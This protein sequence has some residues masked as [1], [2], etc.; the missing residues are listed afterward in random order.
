VDTRLGRLEG[1]E[2]DAI[3]LACAGLE[4][5]GRAEEGTPVAPEALLPAAGQGCLALEARADDSAAVE[6]A[7]AL[8]DQDALVALLAERALVRALDASC[9]TPVGALASPSGEELRLSAY[10]GLPDGSHWIRDALE[11]D[12]TDPAAL[13]RAVAERL[14]AAGAGDVLAQAEAY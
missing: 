12:L 3:V 5:L 7:A 6:R 8:T 2:L 10:V 4:R 11:G 1:D 9:R 14:L 13:G